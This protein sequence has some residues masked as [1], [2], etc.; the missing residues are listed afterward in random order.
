VR[1]GVRR[2]TFAMASSHPYQPDF[3]LAHAQLLKAATR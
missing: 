2:S 3:A 1:T